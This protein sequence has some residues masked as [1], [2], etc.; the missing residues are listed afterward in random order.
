MNRGLPVSLRAR[1]QRLL[2]TRV[3]GMDIDPSAWIDP[4]ALIDRTW[5]RGVHIGAQT[6]IAEEA[7]VLTHDFTRGVRADTRIGRRCYLGP[8]AIVL[9]GITIGDDCVV[10]PG[11]L[12]NRDMPPN[13]SATGNPVVIRDRGEI[14]TRAVG[15]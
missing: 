12:V 2:Q 14:E 9:P 4:T 7:V 8:R 11:A 5:P 10:A 13:S 15:I 1:F 3:W 6:H